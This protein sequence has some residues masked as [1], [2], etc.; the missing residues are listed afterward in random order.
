[1]LSFSNIT[2]TSGSYSTLFVGMNGTVGRTSNMI[3]NASITTATDNDKTIG[4]WLTIGNNTYAAPDYAKY[5]SNGNLV[6]MTRS[7]GKILTALQ[8]S[9]LST[10]GRIRRTSN[11][12]EPP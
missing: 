4:P 10:L 11:G 5:E 6:Y 9:S 8:E 2:R 1:M 12:P 7:A 3:R